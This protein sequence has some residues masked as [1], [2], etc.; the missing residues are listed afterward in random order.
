[1]NTAKSFTIIELLI[2][3]AIFGIISGV[4]VVTYDGVLGGVTVSRT[5]QRAEQIKLFTKQL[6]TLDVPS[7]DIAARINSEFKKST[8]QER[9]IGSLPYLRKISRGQNNNCGSSAAVYTF[10]NT[11]DGAATPTASG[12]EV[13]PAIANDTDGVYCISPTGKTTFAIAMRITE[14]TWW[15]GTDS[16]Y[17]KYYD[18]ADSGS[19]Y[20]RCNNRTAAVGTAPEAGTKADSLFQ[21]IIE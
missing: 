4:V 10:L 9:I 8:V 20:I 17:A 11:L 18:T 5:E 15:C 16:G 7:R 2:T 1:M 6:E 3:I 14:T 12:G 19:I 13:T 21:K